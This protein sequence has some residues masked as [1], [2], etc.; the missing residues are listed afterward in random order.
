VN[1]ANGVYRAPITKKE[2]VTGAGSIIEKL[3]AVT[4]AEQVAELVEAETTTENNF[5]P[6]T[7]RHNSDWPDQSLRGEAS[8]SPSSM[9]NPKP[10]A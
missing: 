10:S 9:R 2:P 3:S 8:T 7:S 4:L 5:V 1:H 6:P